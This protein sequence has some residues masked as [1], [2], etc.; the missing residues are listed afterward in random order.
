MPLQYLDTRLSAGKT[1]QHSIERSS[2]SKSDLEKL[3]QTLA[4]L[5]LFG[6]WEITTLASTLDSQWQHPSIET[7][8]GLASFITSLNGDH[9]GRSLLE[10]LTELLSSIGSKEEYTRLTITLSGEDGPLLQATFTVSKLLL[11]QTTTEP[12]SE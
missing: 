1:L 4:V 11:L 9:V 6:R 3:Q 8:R 2:W 12:G 5:S 10:A 7:W